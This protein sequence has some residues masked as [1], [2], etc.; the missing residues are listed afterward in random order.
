MNTYWAAIYFINNIKNLLL[1]FCFSLILINMAEKLKS[2]VLKLQLLK[3]NK[4]GK[5]HSKTSHVTKKDLP[6]ES[7]LILTT[8]SVKIFPNSSQLY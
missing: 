5:L 8:A 3:L 2:L 4:I 7:I 1:G 6:C